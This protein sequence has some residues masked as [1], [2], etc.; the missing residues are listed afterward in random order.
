MATAEYQGKPVA[1]DTPLGTPD[2]AGGGFTVPGYVTAVARAHGL[3]PRTLWG[4]FG[5]ESNYGLD[6]NASTPN[7]AGALGPFQFLA[8]TWLKYGS[9]NPADRNNFGASVNAAARYLKALGA[10][11]NINSPATARALNEYSGGGGS[12][13]V[14]SVKKKST[15]N[16]HGGPLDF[17]V[18]PVNPQQVASGAKSTIEDAAKVPGEFL[19]LLTNPQ[20][21]LRLVE[22]L[23]G[24]ALLLMGLKTFTG[25]AVDPVGVVARGAAAVA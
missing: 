19:N 22:I 6:K 23:V 9:S 10:D 18:G 2:Q 14:A 12:A 21:W 4:V 15:V 16:P 13:Y 17:N 8:D 7:S 25:G 1:P 5:T 24:A 11:G 20:T 3:D